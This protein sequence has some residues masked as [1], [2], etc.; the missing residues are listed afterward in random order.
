LSLIAGGER[1]RRH[2]PLPSPLT[3]HGLSG[4]EGN[5]EFEENQAGTSDPA[6]SLVL[7]ERGL[8][9]IA[10]VLAGSSW[11]LAEDFALIANKARA[12]PPVAMPDLVKLCKAQTNR[13]PDGKADGDPTR[14]GGA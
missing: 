4:V 11:S 7:V 1:V 6:E 3:V 13:W 12:V 8:L 10:L 5:V 9:L 14:S 2:N